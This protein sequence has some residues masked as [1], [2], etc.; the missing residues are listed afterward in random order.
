MPPVF[1]RLVYGGTGKLI[2]PMALRNATHVVVASEMRLLAIFLQ[3][4]RSSESVSIL[5]RKLDKFEIL[6]ARRVRVLDSVCARVAN[7]CE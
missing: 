4:T 3:S 2:S 1:N 7:S 6:L 5:N